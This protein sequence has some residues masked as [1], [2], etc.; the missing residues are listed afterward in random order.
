MLYNITMKRMNVSEFREKCLALLDEL[1][2]EGILITKRGKPVARLLPARESD[3]DLIGS[4]AGQL[5]ISGNVF[6]TDE[7]WDA[8]S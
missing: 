7:T 2:A 6:S 4:L 1:P 8:E 5:N 3:G